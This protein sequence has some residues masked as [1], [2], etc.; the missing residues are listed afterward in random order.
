[1]NRCDSDEELLDLVLEGLDLPLEL[2]ALV[3][4]H[5]R[6]DDG[7]R[8]AASAAQRLPRAVGSAGRR[9][10]GASRDGKEGT[11]VGAG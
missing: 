5:R 2:R 3:G 6:R 9:E 11:M 4:C 1:M 7:P 10:R 8:H